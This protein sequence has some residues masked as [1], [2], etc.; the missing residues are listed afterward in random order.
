MNR[1]VINF[2]KRQKE[3]F[4]SDRNYVVELLSSEHM[5]DVHYLNLKLEIIDANIKAI[6]NQIESF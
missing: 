2:L 3:S 6:D 5:L 4:L 1:A